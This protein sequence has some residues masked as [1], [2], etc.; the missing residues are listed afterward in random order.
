MSDLLVERKHHEFTE[1]HF[2]GIALMLN[3]AYEELHDIKSHLRVLS[4]NK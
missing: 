4:R 1:E 3:D 2:L